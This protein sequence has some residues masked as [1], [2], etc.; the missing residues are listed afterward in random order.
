M[1]IWT[2]DDSGI[3]ALDQTDRREATTPEWTKHAIWYQIMVD[4]FRNGDSENDPSRTMPWTQSWYQASP[5][6]GRD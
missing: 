3:Y 6:E 5:W 1:E 4:R 2:L